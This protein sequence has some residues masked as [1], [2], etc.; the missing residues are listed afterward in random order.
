MNQLEEV[1][2]ELK[3]CLEAAQE[4]MGTQFNKHVRKTPEWDVGEKV[5]LNGQNILTTRPSPKLGH[6]WLG[7]FPIASRISRSTY[8]L[9]LP[10]SM[11]RIHPVF[12]VSMLRK[13]ATDTVEDRSRKETDPIIV[14]R[15]TKWEVK[16]ILDCRK[17]G[18]RREYLV[19]WKGFGPE[20][21][22]W[23]PHGN[24]NNCAT[25]IRKFDEQYPEAALWH[26]R[27]RQVR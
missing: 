27:R 2:T 20:A 9:T 6:K 25:T 21:N 11:A 12:H 10:L 24:L 14:D 26:K 5:W 7:P 4:A 18:K 1:Q 3:A 16:E 17:I 23:E 15:E 19:S 22:S 13:H 8:K